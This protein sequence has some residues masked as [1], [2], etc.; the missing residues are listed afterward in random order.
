M[1][2]ALRKIKRQKY[3]LLMLAPALILTI[4]FSYIPLSG[5]IMAFTRYQVGFS[6]FSGDWT[7]L[8]QFT[9]FFRESTDIWYLLRNTLGINILSIVAT[10]TSALILALLLKEVVWKPGAKIVQTITFFPFFVSWV[11]TYSIVWGLFSVNSGVVNQLLVSAGI[12]DK[13]INIMGSPQY[14]WTLMI[15][16]NMWKSM[17][18]NCVIFLAALSGIPQEQYESASIDGAGRF[19]KV[20][21]ITL[22][23]L[24]PTIAVL[25]V[26]NSGWVFNSNLEQFF[27]FTNPT[28]WPT[29]EVID[30]YIYRFGLKLLDFSYATAVGIMKTVIS[31]IML[32]TVNKLV[33]KLSGTGVF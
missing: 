13:G 4:V 16:L 29:M 5:W 21:Y 24:V 23:H 27:I 18:Y 7:G 26:L 12:L 15:F 31:L 19:S 17:G 25:L 30:M 6:M 10:L 32:I 28:N 22:P 1:S 14:S 9:K 3:I 20:L 11:I 8:H 2:K 33:K